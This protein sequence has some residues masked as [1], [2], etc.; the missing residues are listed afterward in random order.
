MK[1]RLHRTL[2]TSCRRMLIDS[3]V[4]VRS[5]LG[6]PSARIQREYARLRRC[7]RGEATTTILGPRLRLSHAASFE[8]MHREIFGREIFRLN[9]TSSSPRMLDC[10]AHVGLA[11]IY[12]GQRH[13]QA[14]ITAFE[15]DPAIAA[16]ARENLDAF[17]LQHVEVVAA[18]VSDDDGMVTF[19]ATGDLAGR[20]GSTRGLQSPSQRDV[21]AVR[22]ARYLEEPVEFLKMDIEGAEEAVLVSVADR[23]HNVQR[24]FVEYH[25]FASES[26]RL[27]EFLTL[28]SDVGFRYYITTAYDF[29]QKP[30]L[31]CGDHC[32]MDV[33]LN[34]FCTRDASAACLARGAACE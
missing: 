3:D 15:A 24:L 19:S 17:G 34:I 9:S 26:Q 27:P 18:A 22:L 25:G 33:Q 31:D 7:G 28:L 5:L 10:G 20:I 29:R 13:P 14:R 23:L 16:L 6:S 1:P 12:L 4:T 11:S 8:G 30:F 2:A 21:P 32:G